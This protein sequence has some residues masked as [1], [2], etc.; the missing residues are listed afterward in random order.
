[1]NLTDMDFHRY[2]TVLNRIVSDAAARA[3]CVKGE[4]K[5]VKPAGSWT[6]VR[7]SWSVLTWVGYGRAILVESDRFPGRGWRVYQAPPEA[8]SVASGVPAT[9]RVELTD[10]PL[11]RQDALY[12]AEDY[13][14]DLAY[15]RP[16]LDDADLSESVRITAA[17]VHSDYKQQ[18]REE[19]A[20]D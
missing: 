19:R 4:G 20:D 11:R 15:S 17:F 9:N 10:E 16:E 8:Y 14:T 5:V 7:R 6:C 18:R 3:L 1:M 2:R 13:M 12:L